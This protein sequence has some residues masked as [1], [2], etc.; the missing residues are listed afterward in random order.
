MGKMFAIFFGK[1]LV[2]MIAGKIAK[3]IELAKILYHTVLSS[4]KPI[5]HMINE[6]ARE[7]W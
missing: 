4:V 7:H 2:L 5:P 6:M 3:I 1:I